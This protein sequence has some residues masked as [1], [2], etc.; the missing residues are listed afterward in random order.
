MI[1]HSHLDFSFGAFPS[2]VLITR[3]LPA[4]SRIREDWKE[5]GSFN[6]LLVCDEHTLPLAKRISGGEKVPFCVIPSGENFKVWPQVET[7]LREARE[8]ELGRDGVFIAI[9]GG[10]L[11]D[12]TAFAASVYMRGAKLAFVSTSLLSMVD[13][14]LGGKT[15]FDLFGVKNLAGTF[16]PARRIYIALESLASL[17]LAEW[18]AGMAELIKTAIIEGDSFLDQID[19]M[20][21]E[22]TGRDFRSGFPQSF[23]R[24]LMNS[25]TE[26]LLSCITLALSC[27]GRIVESD[28]QEK[29]EVRALLNLG[30]SFAHALESSAGL[31]AISHGEAVAW[32]IARSCELGLALGITPWNRAERINTSLRNWGYE[33]TVPHPL[34]HDKEKFMKALGS[35]KKKRGG[36]PVF[37]VPNQFGA[38]LVYGGTGGKTLLESILTQIMNGEVNF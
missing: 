23:I 10:V 35:D 15:G 32:G 5:E 38:Q 18:K 16:Y 30:H 8:A 6:P 31:G 26:T 36:Q 24:D 27:K 17:P 20:R 12:L 21:E 2:S 29:G 4:L 9:G 13:A 14:S 3:G 11:G 33:I 1:I 7:I 28:P 19:S 25:K 37:V 22:Y 34:V